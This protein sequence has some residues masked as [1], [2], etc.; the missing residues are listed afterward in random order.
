MSDEDARTTTE[1]EVGGGSESV[2]RVVSMDVTCADTVIV[3]TTTRTDMSVRG[4]FEGG[5]TAW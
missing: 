5:F 4:L 1:S 2:T 3:I